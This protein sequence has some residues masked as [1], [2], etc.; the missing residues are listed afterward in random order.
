M[1]DRQQP[2][3]SS[4]Q[5]GSATA[6]DPAAQ[7][8]ENGYS[9]YRTCQ[10]D[11]GHGATAPYS[12]T[13]TSTTTENGFNGDLS[14]RPIVPSVEDS[15]N[16]P[17]S[18]PPSPSAEQFG[19]LEQEED[20]FEVLTA[21]HEEEDIEAAAHKEQEQQTSGKEPELGPT[22]KLLE[23]TEDLWKTHAQPCLQVKAA[24][25]STGV[26][27]MKALDSGLEHCPQ[28]ALKMDTENPTWRGQT[29]P[30]DTDFPK[31]GGYPE[32]LTTQL[33][34]ILV[35]ADA[36]K[37]A[38]SD[39]HSTEQV[40]KEEYSSNGLHQSK[41]TT[42]PTSKKHEES[43]GPR[44]RDH[45]MDSPKE[46]AEMD[47]K[48]ITGT[49]SE[50]QPLAEVVE[51]SSVV[52]K[53]VE[54]L[55][56]ET[57]AALEEIKSDTSVDP[58]RICKKGMTESDEKEKDIALDAEQLD[59]HEEPTHS[60]PCMVLG[61][62]SV[63]EHDVPCVKD[64]DKAFPQEKSTTEK[65]DSR[66]HP[67]IVDPSS[68][69]DMYLES[70]ESDKSGMSSYFETSAVKE[71][72]SGGQNEGYYELTDIT[73]KKA[74][75]QPS[76]DR[77]SPVGELKTHPSTERRDECR[78]S[79][80][81]LSMDQRSYSLNIPFAS[82]EQGGGQGQLR[83]FS[84]LATDILSYTSGSLDESA[85]YLP[86]TTPSAEKPPAFPPFILGSFTSVTAP[87]CEATADTKAS[88]QAES[89]ES[90]LPMK[91][92]N[93][94][95]TIMAPDL[96]EML[97]LAG[98]RSRI[99]SEGTDHEITR[100]KSVP[101]DVSAYIG[102][103]LAHLG[104]M[105][106]SQK[107]TGNESQIDDLGYCVFNEY[108]GPMPSPADVHSPM[109]PLPPQIFTTMPS[110]DEKDVGLIT[111]D[112]ERDQNEQEQKVK[113]KDETKDNEEAA[114]VSSASKDVKIQES[115]KELGEDS[116]IADAR[117]AAGEIKTAAN[118]PTSLYEHE[119][120]KVSIKTELASD[121][122]DQIIPEVEE[123]DLSRE[124]SPIP[125][126]KFGIEAKE[127]QPEIQTESLMTPTV[128]LTTD[129]AKMESE[130]NSKLTVEDQIATYERQ[131][132]KL[133]TENRPLSVEE[134][135]ELQE[136]REK[137]KDKPDLVHQEA[138]EEVDAEDVYQLT[139]IGKDRI[140]RPVEPSPT[141]SMESTAEEEVQQDLKNEEV[142]SL[143]AKISGE[144]LKSNTEGNLCVSGPL[145]VKKFEEAPEAEDV[146]DL[147]A[148][149]EGSTTEK[150]PDTVEVDMSK[151]KEEEV[152]PMIEDGFSPETEPL[153]PMETTTEEHL[154]VCEPDNSQL[155]SVEVFPNQMKIV[156]PKKEPISPS[157]TPSVS[158]STEEKV[159]VNILEK[160]KVREEPSE[161]DFMKPSEVNTEE[162]KVLDINAPRKLEQPEDTGHSKV[163]LT[164]SESLEAL[165]PEVSTK[166]DVPFC[167]QPWESV[168]VTSTEE[169]YKVKE[170]DAEL[171]ED[172]E[173]LH[174]LEAPAA[175]EKDE[176]QEKSS[177]KTKGDKEQSEGRELVET[178]EATG[179]ELVEPH[180]II[181]SIVTV[182]EDFITV[183][184]TIDE[185]VEPGHS[186]HFSTHLEECQQPNAKEEEQ[187]EKDD[188]AELSREIEVEAA[189]VEEV[190]DIPESQDI[191]DSPLKE[192]VPESECQTE[193]YDDYK[194]ETTIDDSIL[195]TDSAW[196]DT[197]DE[198]RSMATEP[199]EPLP[200][201]Q[202]PVKK[203]V[204]KKQPKEKPTGR[205]KGRVS[206][207]D[208]KPTQREFNV[209]LREEAKNKKAIIKKADLTKKFDTQTRSPSRKSVL[210]PAVRQPR[211]I[212]PHACAKR[213]PTGL[214]SLE[215]RQP[216]NLARRSLERTSDR[217]SRSPEKRS[218]LP[219]PTAML[220]HRAPAGSQDESSTS[221][222]CSSYTAPRRPTSFPS[223]GRAERRS[224]RAPSMT[225]MD[226]TRSRSARSGSSTPHTPGSTS[227]T[228]STPPSYSC[229]T[230]GT[231]GTPSY[232]RTPG[233]PKSL[234]LS[235]ERKVA[236]IRTP[237]KS[238]ATTPKQLRVIHQPLPDLKNV[239]SKI[240]STENIKYQPK[241]GQVYIQN[242]KIDVS[243]VTSKCGSLSN[244]HHRPGGGNVRIESVKLDFK[245]KAQAKVGSLDNAHHIPG[246]GH[247]HIESHKLTFRESAKARVDHGAEIVTQSPVLSGTA[248]PHRLS[249]ISSTGSINLLESPQLATLA[250]D[251][252]AA[253][254]KQGL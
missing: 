186:V 191:Q 144:A 139:S 39:N 212:Q 69:L 202:S 170:D 149:S 220:S 11:G 134:E 45:K 71:D 211:P 100:R 183:V 247:I 68:T 125:P 156:S 229:R 63:E 33:K 127:A 248:S 85:D 24:S 107:A 124:V 58:E 224:K 187:D 6:R 35:P 176:S 109:D 92:N 217:S 140:T 164:Q 225:G 137:V 203:P 88:P 36:K 193:P 232:P 239:K 133:E 136:L 145:L 42:E 94:N 146:K 178:T 241:A 29:S 250:E 77:K 1:A 171:T 20:T 80:S 180:A 48:I 62:G 234:S 90:P 163:Q 237:P 166:P 47:D 192:V 101:A 95:T 254:A 210:K 32:E 113:V 196:V 173:S 242:K 49:T 175:L 104:F 115:V 213:K 17:P 120:N 25:V 159:D 9:T 22:A 169:K 110:E 162:V 7:A 230:P 206:S 53:S 135:R 99:T 204:V 160:P 244:I 8:E 83:N 236:I 185:G 238:P 86:V 74:E 118:I 208:R 179:R 142:A 252:T 112:E 10:P 26:A 5:W 152:A 150:K 46:T 190:S 158:S 40:L 143:K 106:Q 30:A 216:I 111:A 59:F 37:F 103:S 122:K 172:H 177:N 51:S 50:A 61:Q 155:N 73:E 218:S 194:D 188:T 91:Y 181:K 209:V 64:R 89:P 97:D 96:P 16:L 165:A 66:L 78:L 154:D 75:T 67:D 114:E 52:A 251:V 18:P 14:G 12:A 228:P 157:A 81:K 235:Q 147:E 34:S 214:G 4:L 245:E 2:E 131:I 27:N 207:L 168:S 148:V 31:V 174:E 132:H 249:N 222:T 84:P 130:E 44:E 117:I 82:M 55:S 138:Y 87:P 182:E 253:L 141:S 19:P 72:Y 21:V 13:A 243:H 65:E 56:H 223:D 43:T 121:I 184:Q 38:S 246:G 126:E 197:Q 54:P 23:Q 41:E 93:K 60:K 105:D 200:K 123:Q 108:S 119:P 226:S 128:V 205:L 76:E 199:I 129:E 28:E 57:S 195:D 15:A 3:D 161:T 215:D 189:S 240:G 231:P 167:T 227:V 70:S 116:L 221:I 198:D 201:I 79:P 102:H 219:R 233:T 153:V 98:T 151:Q